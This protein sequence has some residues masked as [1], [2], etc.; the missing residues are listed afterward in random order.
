MIYAIYKRV[1]LFLAPLFL[2]TTLVFA[3]LTVYRGEIIL[4]LQAELLKDKGKEIKIVIEQVQKLNEVSK[5]YEETKQ[6]NNTA[7]QEK[8]RE[9]EKIND[10]SEHSSVCITTDGLQLYNSIVSNPTDEPSK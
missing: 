3:V 2:L 4:G 7:K 6:T 10:Q 9:V 1:S 8:L 5:E